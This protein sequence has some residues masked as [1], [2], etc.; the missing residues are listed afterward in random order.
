MADLA[1]QVGVD[2]RLVRLLDQDL[3]IVLCWNADLTDVDLWVTEPNN[4]KC[5]YYNKRTRMGGRMSP[6][7]TQGY[8]PEEYVLRRG[9]SGAYRNPGKVL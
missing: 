2:E 4:E 8:G 3:R 5:F 9:L 7:F 6:D 1:Q